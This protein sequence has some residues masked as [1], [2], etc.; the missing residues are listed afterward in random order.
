[1]EVVK[2]SVLQ[3][4]VHFGDLNYNRQRSLELIEI[5]VEQGAEIVLMP[6]LCISGYAFESKEEAFKLSEPVGGVTEQLWHE[7]ANKY[8]IIIA[9]GIAERG[10]TDLYNSLVVIGAE[11]EI[12][13]YRKTHLFD[14]EKLFFVQGE[15]FVTFDAKNIKVGLMVCYDGWFPEVPRALV[16]EGAELILASGCWIGDPAPDRELS[17]ITMHLGHAYTNSVYI[18]CA[19]RTGEERGLHYTGQ[20]VLLSPYGIL[21]EPASS[22]SDM[23]LTA[24]MYPRYARQ[25]RYTEL[26]HPIED[27]RPELYEKLMERPKKNLP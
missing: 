23:V 14:K 8:D 19:V 20:S 4:D 7:I 6:E 25:K 15:E 21:G 27:R 2:V 10:E 17:I 3:W 1:M 5:A 13:R 18:A 22:D 12:A 24:P 26:A 16:L 11:G 9:G